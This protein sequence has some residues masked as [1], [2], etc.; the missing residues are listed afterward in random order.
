MLH[1]S[2]LILK[3]YL[4]NNARASLKP[5]GYTLISKVTLDELK[6]DTL[7]EAEVH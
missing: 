3:L 1:V 4:I 2:L 7:R 6:N 5:Y